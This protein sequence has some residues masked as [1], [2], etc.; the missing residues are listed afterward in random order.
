MS[1]IISDLATAS[2]TPQNANAMC[3][4][5]GKMLKAADMQMRYGTTVSTPEGNA[6]VRDLI[7]VPDENGTFA[8][9]EDARITDLERQLA[10]LK[11]QRRSA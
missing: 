3:N 8:N 2:I 4:A 5:T 11:D 6:P 9:D 10:D 7:L 1:A